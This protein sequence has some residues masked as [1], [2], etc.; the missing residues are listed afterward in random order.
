MTKLNKIKS[1]EDF[2]EYNI[3]CTTTKE[4]EECLKMLKDFGFEVWDDSV[5]LVQRIVKY[6][7]YF[8]R[9]ISSQ[10][11]NKRFED[12]NFY[13]FKKIYKRLKKQE[14]KEQKEQKLPD[15]ETDE[16]GRVIKINNWNSDIKLYTQLVYTKIC[17]RQKDT[18][19]RDIKIGFVFDSEEAL[20][21]YIKYLTIHTQLKNLAN[22]LN[23]GKK[24][25]WNNIMK[26]KFYLGFNYEQNKI[27]Y[28]SMEE[29]KDNSIYCLDENFCNEALKEIGEEDLKWYLQ[30]SY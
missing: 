28:D 24:I 9:F 22:R 30:Q 23:N 16:N 6:S 10:E 17:S 14:N 8:N 18:W 1:L 5:F 7:S 19:E 11:A 21:N 13:Q 20:N 3:I 29:F 12:I 26:V 15:F 2:K 27:I 25:D 4:V